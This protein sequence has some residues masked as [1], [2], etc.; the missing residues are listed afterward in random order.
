[1]PS[2]F[3]FFVPEVSRLS[4]RRSEPYMVLKTNQ[5]HELS[6]V[7]SFMQKTAHWGCCP[8]GRVTQVS[9]CYVTEPGVASFQGGAGKFR[10]SR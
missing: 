4:F 6:R 7:L 5:T 3:T 10:G 9:V 1:M 2:E 8:P